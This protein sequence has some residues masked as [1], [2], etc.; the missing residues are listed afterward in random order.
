MFYGREDV[1]EFIEQNLVGRHQDSPIVLSGQQRIGKTSVLLQLHRRLGLRYRC[2]L[3]DFNSLDMND[4]ANL[5]RGIASRISLELQGKHKLTVAVPRYPEFQ[6]DPKYAFESLFL[7]LVWPAL[8]DD[9]LVLMLDEMIRLEGKIKEGSLNSEI[10]G[11]LKHLME[12][13]QRL[14][15]IF[16]LGSNM[17]EMTTEYTV[18]FSGA[19][20]HRISFLATPA[21]C[22]LITQPVL[23][24]YELASEAVDKILQ[25]TSGHPYYTQLVCGS[26]F[27]SWAG[28]PRSVMNPADVDLVLAEAVERG[29]PNLTH[30]WQES[31]PMEKAL[32]AGMAVAMQRAPRPVSVEQAQGMW[33]TVGVW[34]PRR[35]AEQAIS[36]LISR[37]VVADVVTRRGTGY[38]FTVDLQRLWLES[39]RHLHR[40]KDE[41]GKEVE[42]WNREACP[43]PTG[44]ITPL[45]SHP[46][47]YEVPPGPPSFPP[48]PSTGAHR[49][50][51][52]R[53]R[54]RYL[55]AA[56]AVAIAAML[57]AIFL[58]TGRTGPGGNS[59]AEWTYTPAGPIYSDPAV[60]GLTVYVG[61][62]DHDVYALNAATGHLDW[63]FST[64]GS[65]QSSPVVAGGV[66]YIGSYDDKVYALNAATGH[67]KWVYPTGNVVYSSPA[68]ADGTVYVG[69]LDGNVYAL[70][71]ATGRLD[72]KY[73]TGGDVYSS[74]AVADGVVYIGSN[75]DYLYALNAVAGTL[76]WKYELGGPVHSS[77]V[78]ANGSVYVGSLDGN[79]YALNVATTKVDWIYHTGDPVYSSPVVSGQTLYIGSDDDNVYALNT[80]NG[81]LR[82]A[83]PT[84]NSVYSGPTVALGMVYAGSFDGNVY[85]LNASTGHLNWKYRTG[86][87]VYSTPAVSDGTVYIGSKEVY[88]MD[89]ATG[90]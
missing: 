21:A 49:V 68:V 64:G 71:A 39:H 19:L 62:I 88:A 6:A 78:V 13:Y 45:G 7:D 48:P 25:I 69:S 50:K 42:Q 32:M 73:G 24:H 2:V 3:I 86:G 20:Y 15:F 31:T 8:G 18:L 14:N 22:D 90:S 59:S 12:H 10:F 17:T 35:E 41:L 83:Y 55:L 47:P 37:D 29:S 63:T 77:P 58:G 11:Y 56:A 70:N 33:H 44:G 27:T 54:R 85:A 81:H 66:V 61:S 87:A 40:V 82:W 84:G 23:N 30:V 57:T 53:R 38:A 34:L 74:P 79:V 36:G 80:A 51:P 9:H 16:S 28:R 5:L 60:A 4:M 67:L 26:L 72:W 65:I 75:N 52:R 76:D 1:F 43:L 46:G 89:A